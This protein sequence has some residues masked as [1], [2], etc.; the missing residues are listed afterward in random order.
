MERIDS[1]AQAAPSMNRFAMTVVPRCVAWLGASGLIPFLAGAV[2]LWTLPPAHA[3]TATAAL[4]GYA[5]VILSFMG[6][7]HWGLAMKTSSA[8]D[9]AR[10]YALGVL[11]ALVGWFALL[12]PS[13]PALILLTVAFTSVYLLD[14][15]AVSARLAPPWYQRLRLPLTLIVVASLFAAALS[16]WIRLP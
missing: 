9:S 2:A 13:L 5:A 14:R 16:V 12:L 10:W 3:E 4:I 6:A 7:I 11:P 15:V 1:G 8:T